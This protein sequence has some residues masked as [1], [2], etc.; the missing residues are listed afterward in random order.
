[1][2]VKLHFNYTQTLLTVRMP[3]FCDKLHFR[4]PKGVFFRKIKVA[5]EK[6]SFTERRAYVM[7]NAFTKARIK[8]YATVRYINYA[9][10]G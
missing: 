5:F 9:K 6:A 7:V 2:F 8:V 4:W 10:K 1:M 3:Y